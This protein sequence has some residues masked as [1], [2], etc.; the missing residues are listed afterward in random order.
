MIQPLVFE[1]VAEPEGLEDSGVALILSVT[2]ETF[3]S[4][5]GDDGEWVRLQS[6]YLDGSHPVLLPLA[7]RRVRI[8]IE[9]LETDEEMYERETTA[10]ML[11][12][13]AIE[14]EVL[15]CQT[16]IQESRQRRARS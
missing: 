1:G 3:D 15:A 12:R 8:T 13:E 16:E 5:S 10:Q 6:S 2:D 11:A 4:P 7:G 14:T 9:A